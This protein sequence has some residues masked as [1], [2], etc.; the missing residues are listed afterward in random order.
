M[1]NKILPLI[2]INNAVKNNNPMR[3]MSTKRKEVES[4]DH[5]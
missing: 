5:I 1:N 2:Y 3:A 4:A